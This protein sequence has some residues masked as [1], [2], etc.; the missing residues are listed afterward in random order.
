MKAASVLGITAVALILFLFEWPKL[1]HGMKREKRAFAVLTV[2]GWALAIL[3]VMYP[4]L[5][6]P[7]QVID[8]LYKP[9]GK[10]LEK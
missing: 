2:I 10:L 9:L 4:N 6:G 7:S 3:L 5:P 8:K 1:R